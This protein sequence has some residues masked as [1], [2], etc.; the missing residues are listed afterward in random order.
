[1]RG[2]V[3]SPAVAGKDARRVPRRWRPPSR[4]ECKSTPGSVLFCACPTKPS[5]D[6]S[7][8]S[9]GTAMRP[10]SGRG[11]LVRTGARATW[12]SIQNPVKA[13]GTLSRIRVATRPGSS[14]ATSSQ[15]RTGLKD[16]FLALLTTSPVRRERA[17]TAERGRA[18]DAIRWITK[19]PSVLWAN[20]LS[21]A[22]A[23]AHDLPRWALAELIHSWG[24]VRWAWRRSREARS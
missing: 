4:S 12:L 1:M 11:R 14:R 21:W 15:G 23:S 10:S 2:R 16:R 6:R 5:A 9:A 19:L 22:V 20:G 13:A 3:G 18:H 24:G 17:G 7:R 8:P